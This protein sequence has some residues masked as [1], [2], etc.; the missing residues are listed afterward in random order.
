MEDSKKKY[1]DLEA[2]TMSRSDA[3]RI[4]ED[5]L[6]EIIPYVYKNSPLHR[7]VWDG[8]K[9]KPEDI[10]SIEDFQEKVPF[11]NKDMIVKYRE[12]TGDP[13]GGV[14][15]TPFRNDSGRPPFPSCPA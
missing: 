5:K 1:W 14:L 10:K 7:E 11:I 4:Q 13:T 3:R 12:R 15:C 6:L 2:E 8:A 9:V